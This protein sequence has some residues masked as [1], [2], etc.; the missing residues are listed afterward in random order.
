MNLQLH[1]T[2]ILPVLR[3]HFLADATEGH[4]VIGSDKFPVSLMN[5]PS[6]VE[7]TRTMDDENLVK[8]GD[9]GQMLLVRPQGREIAGR[10]GQ[11]ASTSSH[12]APESVHG[13][14]PPMANAREKR[15]RPWPKLQA[16]TV[17]TVEREIL[18]V[19][20]G[21]APD[22]LK[23]YDYDEA[24]DAKAKAWKVVPRT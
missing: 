24:F 12:G 1:R 10:D 13:L 3:F 11:S 5:M 16:E 8:V 2:L 4:L 6:I 22:N 18:T 17:R 9:I 23:Y 15:F 19:I 14:T 7:V 20:G 21:G